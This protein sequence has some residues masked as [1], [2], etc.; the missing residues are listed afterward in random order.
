MAFDMALLDVDTFT[1]QN[2]LFSLCGDVTLTQ[3]VIS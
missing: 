1:A 3:G 2:P